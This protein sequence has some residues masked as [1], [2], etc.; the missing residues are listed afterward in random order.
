MWIEEETLRLAERKE[1][2]INKVIAQNQRERVALQDQ[3]ALAQPF[4]VVRTISEPSQ[5]EQDMRR[6]KAQELAAL[7]PEDNDDNCK[8]C[9]RERNEDFITACFEA[10]RDCN[11]C[12][13]LWQEING[14]VLID[15]KTQRAIPL[16]ASQKRMIELQRDLFMNS[17]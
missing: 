12:T 3:A 7:E 6:F 16:S 15:A 11:V 14:E 5:V 13:H 2:F 9:D 17:L 4:E 8:V 10:V 1:A